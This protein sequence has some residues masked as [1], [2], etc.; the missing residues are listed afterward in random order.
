MGHDAI[1]IINAA[2]VDWQY[3]PVNKPI[4]VELPIPSRIPDAASVGVGAGGG[5]TW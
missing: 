3:Q 2:R 1:T 5:T 4:V